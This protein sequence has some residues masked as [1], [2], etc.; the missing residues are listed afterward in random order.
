MGKLSGKIAVITGGTTGI[1]LAT[2]KLF[3]AEGAQVV[4]TGRSAGALAEAQK[5]LGTSALV[6]QSDAS[7]LADVDALAA[8]VREKFGRID[9]L[10]ANAGI[11][12]FAPVEAV[13][14][15]DFDAHFGTNVK[16]LYFTVQKTLPLIP[17]GGTILLNASIVSRKGFPGASIYSAT[18]AAVRSFGRT[19]AA[20]LAPRRI[21]VNTIS[22][23]PVDTP[24]YSKMGFG[25]DAQKAF[26]ESMAAGVSLKRF[27]QPEELAKAALFLVSDDASFVVGAELFVD[28]GLAEL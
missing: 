26:E 3:Q 9:I 11:A 13:T 14:E 12:K 17:E 10:F 4:V 8:T 25:A 6:L 24:I 15:E 18:K 28:G 5:A 20:E 22:P 2:A 1:G 7:R 19:L 27:G 23:G 16:G 21:R